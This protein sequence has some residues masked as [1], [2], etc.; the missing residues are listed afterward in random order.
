MVKRKV[1][2]VLHKRRN[3]RQK[4]VR[5]KKLRRFEKYLR[6]RN[7]TKGIKKISNRLTLKKINVD[8]KNRL[9]YN[10]V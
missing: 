7:G 1:E 8:S 5:Q 10:K 2:M 3:D 4:A 9:C 6:M